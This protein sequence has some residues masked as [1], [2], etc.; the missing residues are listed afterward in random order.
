[1]LMPSNSTSVRRVID[2]TLGA[3]KKNPD[4]LSDSLPLLNNVRR[5]L[6]D[7]D[8]PE[9]AKLKTDA[10]GKKLKLVVSIYEACMRFCSDLNSSPTNLT[11]MDEHSMTMMTLIGK[12]WI[13]GMVL[14]R[15]WN[16]T[17]QMRLRRVE[18]LLT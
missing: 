10:N 11:R 9:D 18:G 8:T 12:P 7:P 16:G 14:R 17:T 5:G 3:C 4:C 1:M 15:I 6:I 2:P 13:F